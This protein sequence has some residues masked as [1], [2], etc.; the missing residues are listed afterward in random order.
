MSMGMHI[1]LIAGGI[2]II[3]IMLF[4]LYHILTYKGD[5]FDLH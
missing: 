2:A 1:I 5:D 4:G 3:L